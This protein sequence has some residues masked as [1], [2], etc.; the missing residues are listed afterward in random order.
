M[1]ENG[2]DDLAAARGI[3]HGLCI[4]LVCWILVALGI[5]AWVTWWR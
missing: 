1:S 2:E 3:V 5:T 4:A